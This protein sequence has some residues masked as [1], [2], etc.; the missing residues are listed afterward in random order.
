[1]WHAK[2]KKMRSVWS[3]IKNSNLEVQ[4][5]LIKML[6]GWKIFL[7]V[8]VFDIY[9]A[10]QVPFFL[11][12][13]FPSWIHTEAHLIAHINWCARKKIGQK[14]ISCQQWNGMGN[15][16]MTHNLMLEALIPRRW[17]CGLRQPLGIDPS[18]ACYFCKCWTNTFHTI[19]PEPTLLTIHWGPSQAVQLPEKQP[20]LQSLQRHR[21]EKHV[22]CS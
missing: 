21:A 5:Q 10:L 8:L 15:F 9:S 13:V 12:S 14:R 11:W 3:Q 18:W 7:L 4:I 1:M 22:P 19:Q 16:W 6:I 20:T 2:K 17:L